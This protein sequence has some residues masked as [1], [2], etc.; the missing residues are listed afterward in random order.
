MKEPY[1]T[2]KKPTDST[3]PW[4]QADFDKALRKA[5][6][7][8]KVAG[9]SGSAGNTG[10]GQGEG[11]GCQKTPAKEPFDTQ[12]RPTDMLTLAG[13]AL[14]RKLPKGGGTP[15]RNRLGDIEDD[16]GLPEC[17]SEE[18]LQQR[19]SLLEC[20]GLI[21]SLAQSPAGA[22]A[23]QAEGA[24]AITAS[25][26]VNRSPSVR[27]EVCRTIESISSAATA[28]HARGRGGEGRGGGEGT[29]AGGDKALD[30]VATDF[31]AGALFDREHVVRITAARAI[32]AVYDP[33]HRVGSKRVLKALDSADAMVR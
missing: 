18:D 33:S 19:R 16:F 7:A 8:H 22:L 23:L 25:L 12:K 14:P 27:E 32:G 17:D 15:S 11:R 31:L 30:S 20:L 10:K 1:D 6:A 29:G 24:C 2:Q 9:A 5:E 21:R 4:L 26:I 13:T 28:A 3:S